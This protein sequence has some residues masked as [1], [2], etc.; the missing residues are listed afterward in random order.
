MK[1]IYDRILKAQGAGRAVALCTVVNTRGSVPRRTGA[2]MLVYENGDTY[3]TI[4][5]GALE[6]KVIENALAVIKAG[7]PKLFTHDLLHQHSMCCGGS[8]EVYIEPQMKNKQLYIFGAGHTGNALA[9]YADKCGF[10][11]YL[12]DD[13]KEYLDNYTADSVNKLH[14][15]FKE[16]LPVLPYTEDTFICIMTYDHAIDR[17]ILFYCMKKP[18][19]YLGMIGSKRKVEV[20]KKMFLQVGT[21]TEQELNNIDMPMGIDIGAEGPDE[22]AIS[23]LSKLIKVKHKIST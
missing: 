12:I 1:D 13:R 20:T 23:I 7:V 9:V 21:V 14:L 5:G 10:E 8:V 16:A 11:V 2:K 19:A 17:D 22:I 15:S 18:H 6:K 3:N 4:G